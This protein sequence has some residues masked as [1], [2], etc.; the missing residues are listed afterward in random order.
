M[1]I[2]PSHVC[3]SGAGIVGACTGDSGGPL[4]VNGVQVGIVSFGFQVC[5]LGLPTIYTR[6]SEFSDW[7]EEN[8]VDGSSS[9]EHLYYSLIVSGVI[10]LIQF[11]NSI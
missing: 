1:I 2:K 6:V 7:I 8:A 11:F 9:Y 4:L 5:T 3:T 10:S